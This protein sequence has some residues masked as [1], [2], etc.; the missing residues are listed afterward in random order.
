[1]KAVIKYSKSIAGT[2]M[3]I[4]GDAEESSSSW[5]QYSRG[6]VR[7]GAKLPALFGEGG[8]RQLSSVP[9]RVT[10]KFLSVKWK[11][12]LPAC[13]PLHRAVDK[14]PESSVKDWEI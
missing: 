3:P 6:T 5:T 13:F 11:S 14:Y 8:I 7:E 12:K 2:K 1:M 9:T 10:S 4:I